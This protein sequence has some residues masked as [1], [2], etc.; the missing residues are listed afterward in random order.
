MTLSYV[1]L[2][3]KITQP[4]NYMLTPILFGLKIRPAIMIS[5][6]CF[7]EITHA[8]SAGK[9]DV[10]TSLWHNLRWNVPFLYIVMSHPDLVWT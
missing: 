8:R 4:L 1:G 7:N 9:K 3:L 10:K 2:N 5:E 6:T